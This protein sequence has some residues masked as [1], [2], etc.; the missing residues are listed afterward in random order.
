[1]VFERFLA[2]RKM[3]TKEF[4]RFGELERGPKTV[5]E[6]GAGWPVCSR[7][8]R[9]SSG[10]GDPA[11]RGEIGVHG[12]LPLVPGAEEG[13]CRDRRSLAGERLGTEPEP[14]ETCDK[15]EERSAPEGAL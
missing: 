15:N 11:R 9:L 2:K 1:V 5:E 14:S 4:P 8:L 10:G 7:C 13:S 6:I 3:G 12:A